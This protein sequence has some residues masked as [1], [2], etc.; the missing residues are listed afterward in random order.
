MFLTSSLVKRFPGKLLAAASVRSPR[1][2]VNGKPVELVVNTKVF[3]DNWG[4]IAVQ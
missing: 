4:S 3:D 2:M 1:E